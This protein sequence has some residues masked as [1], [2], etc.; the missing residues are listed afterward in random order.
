[1]E[2]AVASLLL[3]KPVAPAVLG[4]PG[5][6]ARHN[7][8]IGRLAIAHLEPIALLDRPAV[9]ALTPFVGHRAARID[10]ARIGPGGSQYHRIERAMGLD[11]GPDRRRSRECTE[12]SGQ[13]NG[14]NT[15]GDHQD[16]TPGSGQMTLRTR[17]YLFSNGN[18]RRMAKD[19]RVALIR[20]R[21]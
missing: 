20:R 12:A 13:D 18:S 15:P 3:I 7:F 1:I 8:R 4:L 17:C 16:D 5:H 2:L 9:A 14:C 10:H 11:P 6:K 19:W 21:G